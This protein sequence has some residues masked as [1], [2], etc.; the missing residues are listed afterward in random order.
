MVHAKQATDAKVSIDPEPMLPDRSREGSLEEQERNRLTLKNGA[1]VDAARA[2]ASLRSLERLLRVEPRLFH[3]LVTIVQGRRNEVTP[4]V[5][6][7]LQDAAF[8]RAG[9]GD[10]CADI[11]D[12]LLSAYQETREG[13]VLVNPFKFRSDADARIVESID[14]ARFNRLIRA[15]LGNNSKNGPPTP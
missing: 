7:E 11:P 12:V 13:P 5:I 15:I 6:A 4:D 8:L 9:T 14:E 2:I 10:V 3:A 1:E